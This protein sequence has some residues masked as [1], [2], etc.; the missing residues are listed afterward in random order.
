MPLTPLLLD[1]VLPPLGLM[2]ALL[3]LI[4]TPPVLWLIGI[5][6]LIRGRRALGVWYIATGLL[7]VFPFVAFPLAPTAAVVA[8]VIV[9]ALMLAGRARFVASQ[10]KG[11]PDMGE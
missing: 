7:L 11:T 6:R 5:M 8:F 3:P 1:G 9:G 4:V 2:L 10:T